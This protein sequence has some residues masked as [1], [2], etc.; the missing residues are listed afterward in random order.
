MNDTVTAY[1]TTLDRLVPVFRNVFDDDSLVIGPS[2]SAADIPDWDSQSHIILI[3]QV[4]QEFGIRF[5]TSELDVLRNVGDFVKLI[6]TKNE[7][8]G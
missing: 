7:N 6:A 2:T 3:L 1:A 4:E 8:G 5:R